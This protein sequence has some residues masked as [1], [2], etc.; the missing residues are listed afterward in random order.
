MNGGVKG[1]RPFNPALP[2][3]L[4]C[5]ATA[6]TNIVPI[7][8][9]ARF[10]DLTGRRFG[11]LIILG[12]AGCVY[13]AGRRCIHWRARCDCGVEC[14]KLGSNLGRRT[15]GCGCREGRTHPHYGMRRHPEYRN[16]RAMIA[17]CCGR[18]G[19][20]RANYGRD[21]VRVCE[22]WRKSFP[23]FLED[24]GPKPSPRHTL[25]RINTHGNYEPG[26]CRWATVTEQLRNTRVNRLVTYR[27]Q[28]K[29]LAAWIEELDLPR[30][31]VRTRIERGWPA[32]EAFETPKGCRA[33]PLRRFIQRRCVDGE[34]ER[35]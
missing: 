19:R 34:G 20:R 14:V 31:M 23:A 35:A 27:G 29:P 24:V 21:G 13:Y 1:L 17:R 8:D 3:P 12:P 32:D 2:Q 18:T 4:L 33:S 7:P 6:V 15:H 16:W 9:G 25:D 28:T 22:R 10:Q 30:G 5:G 11:M 26:N